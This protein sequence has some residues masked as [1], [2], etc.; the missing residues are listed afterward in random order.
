MALYFRSSGS[1]HPVEFIFD[2]LLQVAGKLD[3]PDISGVVLGPDII[4][5]QDASGIEEMHKLLWGVVKM[6]YDVLDLLDEGTALDVS[7]AGRGKALP[8][9]EENDLRLWVD[10]MDIGDKVDVGFVELRG[11]N[12]VGSRVGVVGA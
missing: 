11:G 8:E 10:D 4:V 3:V 9:R 1:K 12:V 7:V 6:R 5:L 2:V